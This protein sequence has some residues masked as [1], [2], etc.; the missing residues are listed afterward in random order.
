MQRT[1]VEEKCSIRELHWTSSRHR[2]YLCVWARCLLGGPVF[3]KKTT[4]L[5]RGPAKAIIAVVT[6][7][8]VCVGVVVAVA[9]AVAAAVAVAVVVELTKDVSVGSDRAVSFCI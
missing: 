6:V 2:V 5:Q 4:V 1:V 8:V 7:G 3:G 9:V